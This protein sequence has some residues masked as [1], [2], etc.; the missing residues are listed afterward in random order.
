[1]SLVET[2]PFPAPH[3]ILVRDVVAPQ[4]CIPFNFTSPPDFKRALSM[5]E[6]WAVQLSHMASQHQ[7]SEY[8]RIKFGPQGTLYI[9]TTVTALCGLCSTSEG[10]AN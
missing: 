9:Y 5:E 3:Q 10:I 2:L 4:P 8:N 1:M 7:T 6:Q